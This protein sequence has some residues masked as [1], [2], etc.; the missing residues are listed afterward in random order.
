MAQIDIRN[1]IVRIKDGYVGPGGTSTVNAPAYSV[2]ATTMVVDNFSGALANNDLFTVA[3]DTTIYKVTAHSETLGN[4]VSVTFTPGL[5]VAVDDNAVIT[6]YQP[7]ADDLTVNNVAGYSI[8][9]SVIAVNGFTGAVS[10]GDKVKFSGHATL[11]NI[12]AHSETLGNTTS[13]T[14]SP[15]LT[16]AVID[17]ESLTVYQPNVDTLLVNH[18]GTYSAGVSTI[19]VTGFSGA[20]AD[21]DYFTI[22]TNDTLYVV[23]S[24]SETLSNTTSITFSPTL[25]A[26][27]TTGDAVTIAP[28]QIEVTIGDGNCSYDEKRS[29]KYIRDRGRLNTVRQEQDEPSEV[30]IDATW[31]FLRGASGDPPTIEDTLKRR[32]QASGWITSAD[33]KCEPYAVDVEIEYD[34]PCS[35]EKREIIVL[36]DFRYESFN[37]D[38]KQGVLAVKGKANVTEATVTRVT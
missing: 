16:S 26:T 4:T 24:H 20:L 28:H 32:G 27:A 31:E 10:N 17:T 33:D 19:R 15:V 22:G 13:I 21:F 11:Y 35:G 3:G 5:V 7:N 8:G 29:F 6:A 2:G 25:A 23:S 18:I 30:S 14:V 37:H 9:D 1:A 38:L 34:P 36:E 12:T